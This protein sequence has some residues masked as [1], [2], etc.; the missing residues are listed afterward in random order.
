M[1][2]VNAYKAYVIYDNYYHFMIQMTRVN[3]HY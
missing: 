1:L 2:H 3:M